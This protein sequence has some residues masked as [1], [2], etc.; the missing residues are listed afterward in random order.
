MER[1]LHS[2]HRA[3]A[4]V[5]VVVPG[6]TV[7]PRDVVATGWEGGNWLIEQG[8]APGDRV[9]VEGVQKVGPGMVVKP[10]PAGP[11]AG[12]QDGRR[13]P[14]SAAPGSRRP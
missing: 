7:K 6:D 14:D 4:T 3:R 11:V 10:V 5:Y 12:G 8:L 2:R 13:A 1:R 9:I